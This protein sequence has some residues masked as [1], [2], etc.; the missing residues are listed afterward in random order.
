MKK[1][2]VPDTLSPGGHYTPAIIS[3]GFVFTSGL[4]PINQQ[5]G[6]KLNTSSFKDQTIMV[7][8][9]LNSILKAAGTSLD[10][11]VKV[12]VFLKNI[13][14]WAEFNS[15]YSTLM[16]DHKPART[17]V[18]VTDLHFGFLIELEAVAEL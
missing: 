10:K 8:E 11:V 2:F 17:V 9:N 13:N 16:G 6:E 18:P 12:S 5:S 15:L 7:F 1:I 14:D 4:L 3:N